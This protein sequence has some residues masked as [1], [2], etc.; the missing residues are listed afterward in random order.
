MGKLI[1]LNHNSNQS[2]AK[3][4]DIEMYADFAKR[5]AT[6]STAK[7]LNVGA[8]VV[9]ESR[10]IYIG[11]NGTLPNTDNA[12][13]CSENKTKPNVIH[14]EENALDKMNAEGISTKGCIIVITHAPCVKCLTRI[15]NVGVDEVIFLEYYRETEHLSSDDYKHVKIFKYN[16]E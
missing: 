13:E 6:R 8:C 10:G 15:A 7:R 1:P 4:S 5:A 12:C 11:Y 9:T 3:L 2:K 14:A 16:G